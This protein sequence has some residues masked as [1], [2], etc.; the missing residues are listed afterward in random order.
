[1]L[2]VLVIAGY[3]FH[4]AFAGRPLFGDSLLQEY[5]RL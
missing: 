3:G 4:T 5:A 2:W 1:V